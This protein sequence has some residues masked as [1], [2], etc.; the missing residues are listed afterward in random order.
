MCCTALF[1]QRL[2]Q[3]QNQHRDGKSGKEGKPQ[4]PVDAAHAENAQ[5]GGDGT[6]DQLGQRVGKRILDQRKVV[7]HS[8]AQLAGILAHEITKGQLAD[9]FRQ[10]HAPLGSGGVSA[11]IGGVVGGKL[12]KIQ[13]HGGNPHGAPN[14]PKLVKIQHLGSSTKIGIEGQYRHGQKADGNE[15]AEVG[16]HRKDHGADDLLG[17]PCRY[18]VYRISLFHTGISVLPSCQSAVAV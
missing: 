11:V 17:M 3:Q 8:V 7:H 10:V 5:H 15:V 12:Q 1:V 4:P 2:H 13:H 16:Q 6:T 9:V 14:H 18:A